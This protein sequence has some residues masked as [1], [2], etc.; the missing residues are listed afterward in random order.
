MFVRVCVY[1][2]HILI[3]TGFDCVWDSK[4]FSSVDRLFRN[5]QLSLEHNYK[6][7][8]SDALESSYK[9][10]FYRNFNSEFGREIYIETFPYVY[11]CICF[12]C[13]NHKL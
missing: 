8:W 11:I 1:I 9:Y 10:L 13:G 3:E 12:R 2:H 5:V 4:T 6:G 7:T